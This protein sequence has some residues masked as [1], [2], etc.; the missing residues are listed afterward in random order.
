MVYV[1][2]YFAKVAFLLLL[3]IAWIVFV[4][5]LRWLIKEAFGKDYLSNTISWILLFSPIAWCVYVNFQF[6]NACSEAKG[7]EIHAAI[8]PRRISTKNFEGFS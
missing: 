4:L 1:I 3:P 6:M 7:S 2:L 5:T 8:P